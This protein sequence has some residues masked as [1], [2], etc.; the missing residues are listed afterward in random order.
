MWEAG[1]RKGKP[2]IPIEM[3]GESIRATRD[4]FWLY[5]FSPQYSEVDHAYLTLEREHEDRIRTVGYY[6]FRGAVP[7]FDQLAQVMDDN[8]Y[9]HARGF[10]PAKG[11]I[12]AYDDFVLRDRSEDA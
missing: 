10:K 3:S 12:E 4:N 11:D 5:T 1:Q 6:M 8:W 9:W 7:N 2:Y